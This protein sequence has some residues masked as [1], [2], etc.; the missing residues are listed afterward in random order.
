MKDA[1]TKEQVDGKMTW[2]E[3]IRYYKPDATDDECEYLLWNET[4]F[5]FSDETTLKQL[6]LLLNKNQLIQ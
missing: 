1:L 3:V 6:E 5:P 4:C 2:R